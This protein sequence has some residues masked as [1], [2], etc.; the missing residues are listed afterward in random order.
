[1]YHIVVEFVVYTNGYNYVLAPGGC[2]ARAAATRSSMAGRA[3]NAAV[4]TN[5]YTPL[6]LSLYIYI[7][8]YMQC[9]YVYMFERERE[10]AV[11]HE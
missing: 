2:G 9:I 8:I 3:G 4:D 10:R 11:A 5:M 1:M 7:Y 6:S